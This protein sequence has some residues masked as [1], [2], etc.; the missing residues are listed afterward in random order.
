MITA[1]G[2]AGPT[3]TV[4]DEFRDSSLPL[5]DT[6]DV[7]ACSVCAGSSF[8]PFAFG[9][10]YEI[11]TCRNE[12]RFVQCSS[13]GHVWLNPRP[14]I[15]ALPIIYPK[16]YY[17]YSYD[18]EVNSIARSAKA[19]L[20]RAKL[21]GVI[22]RVGQ[23][24]HSYADVG[25]GDGRF[26]KYFEG[27]GV[28]KSNLYGLELDAAVVQRLAG[29]GYQVFC[30]RVEDCTAIPAGSI[31]LVTMFH[32]IEH[33]DRPEAVVR[34]IARWLGPGGVLALETPNL[35][36]VDAR[37]FRRTFW[38]GYH[39]PRHWHLFTPR[40]LERLLTDNG[41]T[42]LATKF[43]TG[44]SFWMYSFH[45]ALRFGKR[46]RPK[47]ARFFNPFKSVLPLAAFT[48]LDKARALLGQRTSAMLMLARK[49]G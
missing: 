4:P 46:P 23:P 8:A 1:A 47:L 35:D 16:T 36:S 5:I 42:P 40:T 19:M 27:R 32:V 10:D 25:C 13:C 41:L 31:D 9:Y 49:A 28:P 37:I 33:V 30:E 3:R 29:Q 17:A 24:V 12:W 21:A 26:L 14:A 15:S 39:I 2:P 48:A 44:H 7:P 43:Q 34:Q 6:E 11:Q 22:P 45:H 18:T 20:D 38:G